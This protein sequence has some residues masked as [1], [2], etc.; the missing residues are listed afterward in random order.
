M[1]ICDHSP[2][3]RDIPQIDPTPREGDVINMAKFNALPAP[4]TAR[5]ISGDE[6]WIETLDVQTGFM[7]L[8]VQGQIDLECFS[9]VAMLID[10]DG[11][12][13]DPDEFWLDAQPKPTGEKGGDA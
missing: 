6:L 9:F 10:I 4:V 2:T 3:K 1:I 5:L 11:G 13:H 7:R 12:E 8:D